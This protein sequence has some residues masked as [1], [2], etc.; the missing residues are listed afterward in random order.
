MP[1][2][3]IQ[4][5]QGQYYHIYNR[6]SGRQPIFRENDN[7]VFALRLVKK[8]TSTFNVSVMAYCLMPNHYHFLLRQDGMES[9]GLVPQRVFNSY[10]KA[11]NKRYGSSGTLFEGRYKGIHVD[12]DI[13]L[14]HL[15]RY[16]HANPVKHGLVSRLEEWPYSNYHEWIGTRNGTLV[17]LASVQEHFPATQTYSQFVLDYLAGLDELP[18]GI[19]PY[20]LE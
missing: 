11:F 5:A 15:C 7:Y 16:I 13:Y 19:E 6:G 9:A 18:E 8:Y 3:R 12:K 14:L 4:F 2:R 10:T 17:D 20:L 1:Y